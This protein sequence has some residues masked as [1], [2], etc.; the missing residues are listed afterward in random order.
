MSPP[1]GE[2]TYEDSK[3]KSAQEWIKLGSSIVSD[4]LRE[5]GKAFQAM[6]GGIRPLGADMKIA[7]PAFTVRCFTGATWAMEKALELAK[8]GD[9]LVVDGGGAADVILMGGLMST[10]AKARGIAGAVLDAAV[11]DVEQII[12]VEFPV[13]SR[14][15]CPRAGTFAEIGEWQ[16]TICCGRLPVNPADWIVADRSGVVVVPAALHDVVYASALRIH[17]REEVVES[18]LRDGKNLT[19]SFAAAGNGNAK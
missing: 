11:R 14:Y 1:G 17:R 18:S 7:G 3:M 5:H 8:P 4:A 9:V 2:E 6:D 19:E 16:T 12:A 10:R 15:I 13:F